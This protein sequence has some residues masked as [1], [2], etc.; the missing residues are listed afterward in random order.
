MSGQDQ[1]KAQGKNGDSQI[2]EME[3]DFPVHYRIIM[4][5]G[6]TERHNVISAVLK[7]L[8]K[9]FGNSPVHWKTPNTKQEGI[10]VISDLIDLHD[11]S[12]VDITSDHQLWDK[13]GRWQVILYDQGK[14]IAIGSRLKDLKQSLSDSGL[15]LR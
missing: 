15:E 6:R 13:T 8:Q 2:P 3:F 12:P 10:T 4:P 11:N 14:S 7:A 1:N 9:T 5:E